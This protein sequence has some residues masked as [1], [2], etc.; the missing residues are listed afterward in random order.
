MDGSRGTGG[1]LQQLQDAPV[2]VEEM[3]DATLDDRPGAHVVEAQGVA[4]EAQGAFEVPWDDADLE[5]AIGAQ[6][7]ASAF[8]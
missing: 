1:L 3:Q 7:S 4:V 8:V 6:A 2:A 5:H